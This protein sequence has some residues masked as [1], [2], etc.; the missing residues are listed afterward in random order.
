MS[1]VQTYEK[2]NFSIVRFETFKHACA[3]TH[4]KDQRCAF[5]L[6]PLYFEFSSSSLYYVSEQRRLSVWQGCA[7]MQVRLSHR[8]SP[9]VISTFFRMSCIKYTVTCMIGKPNNVFR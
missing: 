6:V 3:A 9:F 8:C 2:R 5:P 4:E 7:D 1:R